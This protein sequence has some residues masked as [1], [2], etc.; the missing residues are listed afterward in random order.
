MF[1]D[2]SRVPRTVSLPVLPELGPVHKVQGQG[3]AVFAMFVVFTVFSVFAVF[4]VFAVHKVQSQ[5]Y[6][7][8]LRPDACSASLQ[9]MHAGSMFSSECQRNDRDL[10]IPRAGLLEAGFQGMSERNLVHG[11]L[12]N[13]H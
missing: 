8:L 13:V 7:E 5:E 11:S 4:V 1:S 12:S 10:C 6:E 9:G 3:L 2:A